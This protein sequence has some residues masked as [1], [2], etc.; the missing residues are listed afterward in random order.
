MTTELSRYNPFDELRQMQR[1]MDRVWG[2]P[3]IAREDVDL[4]AWEDTLAVDV[5]DHNNELVVKAAMPGIDPK[6]VHVDVADGVL[7][8][9]GETKSETNVDEKDW[10][11]REVRYGKCSRSFRLPANL[12][13]ANATAKVENGMLRV[14]FPKTEAAKAKSIAVKVT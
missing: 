10:H 11:R 9:R 13:V 14:A 8:I 2:N 6:D 1:F 12:D 3:R 7:Y 5:F 4:G